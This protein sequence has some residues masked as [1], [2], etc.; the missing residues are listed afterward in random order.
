MQEPSPAT[1]LQSYFVAG[2]II[3]VKAS[4]V[5]QPIKI[6]FARLVKK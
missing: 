6:N 1:S 3:L 4:T 2:A 5:V